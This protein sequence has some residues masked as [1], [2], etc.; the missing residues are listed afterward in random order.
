MS[1]LNVEDSILLS[2]KKLIGGLDEENTYFDLDLKI[3]INSTFTVL[4]QVGVGPAEPFKI[5]GPETTWDEFDCHDLEAVKEYMYL[6]TR[7]TFDPPANSSVSA[8]YN[9]RAAELEWR[10]GIFSE[11]LN[12]E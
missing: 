8:A 5:T 3:F 9:D 1:E 11:E 10:L 6:K 7:L 2:V 12:D 4:A